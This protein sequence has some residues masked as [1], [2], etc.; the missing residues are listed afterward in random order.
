MKIGVLVQQQITI[1]NMYLPSTN[2]DMKKLKIIM[3]KIMM[4]KMTMKVAVKRK[5]YFRG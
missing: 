4:R 5:S 2:M 3:M 1:K